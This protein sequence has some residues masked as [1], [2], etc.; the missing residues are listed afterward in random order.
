[1]EEAE[2]L[3][4][5][6]APFIYTVGRIGDERVVWPASISSAPRR[7]PATGKSMARAPPEPASAWPGAR[8]PRIFTSSIGQSL[9]LESGPCVVRGIVTTGGAEDNRVMVP[10]DRAAADAGFQNAASVVEVRADGRR[11]EE[12]RASLAR[13]LPETDVRVLHAIAETEASVVLKVRTAVFFW[14]S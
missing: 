12:I 2:R 8:S 4:A 10:F 6:A 13:A 14:R 3:G 9:P 5:A 11:V 1:M 7:S